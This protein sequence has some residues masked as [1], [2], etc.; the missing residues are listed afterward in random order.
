MQG[1]NFPLVAL[2]QDAAA[3]VYTRAVQE[4]YKLVS[5]W[6]H[7]LLLSAAQG[8][9]FL[10]AVLPQRK[11]QM[12]SQRNFCKLAVEVRTGV[13]RNLTLTPT[14]TPTLT[15]QFQTYVMAG[16]HSK[17]FKEICFLAASK[18]SQ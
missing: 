7:F 13:R 4:A 18:V 14:L 11:F 8:I 10:Y 15:L 1:G 16:L 6:E 17:I 12:Q 9:Y 3:A 5:V 2:S